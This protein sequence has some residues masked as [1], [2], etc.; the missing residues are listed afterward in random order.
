[1]KHLLAL[2]LVAVLAGACRSGSVAPTPSPSPSVSASPSASPGPATHIDHDVV[3][4]ALDR[5]PPVAAHVAGAGAGGSSEARILSRLVSLFS[6]AAPNGIF[7]V[8]L[9]SS[10]RPTSVRVSDDIATVD[11]TVPDGLWGVNGSA[12]TRSFIQQV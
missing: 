3:Y 8:A 11:F 7:N 6:T 4:F 5:L 10:A 9:G 1:M 2:G 12:G